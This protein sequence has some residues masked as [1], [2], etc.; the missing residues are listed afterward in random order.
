[1]VGA[2]EIAHLPRAVAHVAL[3]MAAADRVIVEDDFERAQPASPEHGIGFPDFSFDVARD[4]TETD[5]L[6]HGRV[7][8]R[9]RL[10][11]APPGKWVCGDPSNI[12]QVDSRR[13]RNG[14]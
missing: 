4:A 10:S 3:G 2:P 1:S 13:G 11:A 6:T 7:P 9:N 14:R 8:R 12:A 5:A